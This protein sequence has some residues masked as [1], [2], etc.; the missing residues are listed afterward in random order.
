MLYIQN[1]H[2]GSLFW[3]LNNTLNYTVKMAYVRSLLQNLDGSVSM[4]CKY[5]KRSFGKRPISGPISVQHYLIR[6][7][8]YR[9]NGCLR[10]DLR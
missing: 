10:A 3:T 7:S 5:L 8:F 2:V 6:R 9:L 1:L 4:N